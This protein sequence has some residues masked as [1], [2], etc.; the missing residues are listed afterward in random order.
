M[1]DLSETRPCLKRLPA[2]LRH[3]RSSNQTKPF[4]GFLEATQLPPASSIRCSQALK[5]LAPFGEE[6]RKSSTMPAAKPSQASIGNTIKAIVAA[7]L[8]PGAVHVNADGGFHVDIHFP[9]QVVD[10]ADQRKAA[11]EAA[12]D[13]EAVA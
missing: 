2:V 9:A 1:T 8:T 13:W 5:R 6:I 12:L 10:E 11:K 3:R 4:F 7:G